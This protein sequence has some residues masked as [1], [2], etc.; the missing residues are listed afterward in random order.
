VEALGLSAVDA[1]TLTAD[2]A[3]GDLYE[4]AIAAGG[5]PRRVANLLL[6]H[7]RRISNEKN[8][9]L[10]ELG[11]TARHLSEV[12]ALIEQNKLAAAEPAGKLLQ[13]LAEGG[14]EASAEQVAGDLGLLQVSDT[15]AID[16]AIDA[17][18]A[19]NPRP[20]QDYRGGK[21]AALG[22]LVGMVMKSVKGL[23][24]KVVQERLAGRL[25]G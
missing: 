21:Q 8:V 25:K 17:L 23:N 2:R 10:G 24:P 11:I 15:S 13:R 3:T 7:G 19:Q 9:P 12:A 20:L 1:A 14:A 16:A 4:G 22:A 6:S 18:V 5:E